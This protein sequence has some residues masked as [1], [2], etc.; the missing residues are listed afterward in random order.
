M[1]GIY[2]DDKTPALLKAIWNGDMPFAQ[3]E[4][5]TKNNMTK[6]TYYQNILNEATPV[7]GV[8]Q[9][10]NAQGKVSKQSFFEYATMDKAV[11]NGWEFPDMEWLYRD[12]EQDLKEMSSLEFFN[13]LFPNGVVNA[14]TEDA[15]RSIV[16]RVCNDYTADGS[17]DIEGIGGRIFVVEDKVYIIMD[18]NWNYV[19]Y[20]ERTKTDKPYR[21]LISE[22][23]GKIWL[24]TN[25]LYYDVPNVDFD[26]D[27]DSPSASM[28]N[29][30][31][32]WG[33]VD[34]SKIAVNVV[35]DTDDWGDEYV[36]DIQVAMTPI[37]E[38]Y[39]VSP[40]FHGFEYRIPLVALGTKED[41]VTA[42]Y[43]KDYET[44]DMD[45]V[46]NP[47]GVTGEYKYLVAEYD[48]YQKG[49]KI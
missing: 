32:T 28:D 41:E 13:V 43:V 11:M 29:W 21:E 48:R 47:D 2:L 37:E 17:V 12:L 8:E 9:E 4:Y 7:Y 14:E 3:F 16:D 34:A 44:V 49:D 26:D 25:G 36:V 1:G 5:D 22:D 10:F 46:Y 31:N 35:T 6:A 45:R 39:N 33:G 23:L 27:D 20:W 19:R 38:R 42:D 30:G 40:S 18:A 24:Y 15:K